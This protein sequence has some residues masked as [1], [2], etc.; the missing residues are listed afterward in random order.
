ML[1]TLDINMHGIKLTM[2]GRKLR[3]HAA[4]L[5][6]PEKKLNTPPTYKGR[7]GGGNVKKKKKQARNAGKYIFYNITYRR[8][9]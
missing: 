3:R 8:F 1:P 7:E 5:P 4:G 2:L 9:P 6:A